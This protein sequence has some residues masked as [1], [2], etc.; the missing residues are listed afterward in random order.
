MTPLLSDRKMS[1]MIEWAETAA[2]KAG[3]VPLVF[4]LGAGASFGAGQVSPSPPPLGQQLY[5][6]LAR[7]F[8]GTWGAGRF[9][10]IA[11]EFRR[12]F[13]A[14]MD[15][16]IG[17]SPAGAIDELVDM[18]AYFAQFEPLGTDLYSE[19]L[20]E[21]KKRGL[22]ARS[23]FCSLNYECV[24]EKAALR[25]GHGVHYEAVDGALGPEDVRVIKPHGS[26]N[27]LTRDTGMRP[28]PY[29]VTGTVVEAGIEAQGPDR[30]L[31]MVTALRAEPISAR[32]RWPVMSNYAS[33]KSTPLSSGQVFQVRIGFSER[34]KHAAKIIDWGS[35][36]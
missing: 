5:D 25:L 32:T 18:A 28:A 2:A 13:E 10:S 3:P 11:D 34:V 17:D 24:F 20:R 9:A 29:L 26:C 8:P 33:N 22:I 23:V 14:A 21:L 35:P 27:F 30:T 15:R 12:D 4:L 19:L 31:P 1:P 16:C 6:E 7:A 36:E